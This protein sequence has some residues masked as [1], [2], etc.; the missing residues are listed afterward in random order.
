LPVGPGWK[1]DDPIYTGR[2]DY[3]AGWLDYLRE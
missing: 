3:W 1:R 2:R